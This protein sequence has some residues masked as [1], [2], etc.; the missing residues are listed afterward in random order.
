[1]LVVTAASVRIFPVTVATIPLLGKGLGVKP[2]HFILAQLNSVTSYVRLV[3]V[4]EREDHVS[5]RIGFFTAFTI[6]TLIVGAIGT[7]LGFTLAGALP[8]AGVQALVFITPLYLLL[9]TARSPKTQVQLSV[10]AGC[11]LVPGFVAWM[12]SMGMLVG[13]LVAGS[14]A[15]VATTWRQRYA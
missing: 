7:L 9:L 13:G 15:Y 2:G 8:V 12:G 6:G 10:V 5:S 4:A 3:D 14:L 11:L 1:M